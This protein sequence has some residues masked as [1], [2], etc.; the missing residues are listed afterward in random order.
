LK[1]ILDILLIIYL[2]QTNMT[3]LYQLSPYMDTL[4]WD[5]VEDGMDQFRNSAGGR[6]CSSLPISQTIY[7]AAEETLITIMQSKVKSIQELLVMLTRSYETLD[8]QE[9]W[10]AKR[11]ATNVIL[12]MRFKS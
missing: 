5:Y 2:H 6:S 10:I 12:H 7:N 3:S 1:G 11:L 9:N 4:L 8:E